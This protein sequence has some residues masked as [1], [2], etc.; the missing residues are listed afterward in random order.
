M[1]FLK[2]SPLFQG[3]NEG[4]LNMPTEVLPGVM[5]NIAPISQGPQVSAPGGGNIRN[6]AIAQLA[7]AATVRTLLVGAALT[8]PYPGFRRGARLRWRFNMAKTAAGTATSLFEVLVGTLG[9]LADTARLSFTKPAGTAAAD[10]AWCEINVYVRTRSLTVGVLVGTFTMGH[11]L[12][13]TGH[14]VI[15]YVAVT[16]V[17]GNFDTITFPQTVSLAIT[18]G[19]ADAITIEQLEAEAFNLG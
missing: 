1:N 7:P 9:T 3:M 11:N 10:E 19:A 12:A 6:F 14:A 17:S 5:T 13:A 8:L 18:T 15:P 16:V 4:R 2:Y